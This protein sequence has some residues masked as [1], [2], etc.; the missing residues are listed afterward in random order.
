M[1]T[2]DPRSAGYVSTVGRRLATI[3]GP[4]LVGFYLHG[5]AVLG[6]FTR[7][8]SDVD[9]LAVTATGLA[10]DA[11]RRIADA[12]SP[13]ALPCPAAGLELSVVTLASAM[14]PAPTPAFELHIAT[15]PDFN[16]RIVDGR[17]HP[18]DPDLLLHFAVCR[19]HGR[20][21]GPGPPMSAVFGPVPRPWLLA[22]LE[23][24]LTWAL[25]HAT[26]EYQ[27]LNACRAWRF[28]EEGA[29]CSKLDG[30]SWAL[31]RTGEAG[32]RAVVELAIA[33]Q[34]SGS[35]YRLP[36]PDPDAVLA[37]VERTLRRLALARQEPDGHHGRPDGD[38]ERGGR[39]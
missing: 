33:R 1:T 17:D 25:R 2:L 10:A 6:G 22:R 4:E 16:V 15:G 28:A 36:A 21:I 11:K 18:G 34:R 23:A 37:L 35:P 26:V 9:L 29:W 3:L 31:D 7:A 19:E 8:R 14:A 39:A 38:A 32:D 5:S 24:E 12:L 20:R 27:V 13:R 30:G